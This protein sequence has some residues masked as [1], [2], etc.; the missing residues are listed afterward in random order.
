MLDAA[1]ETLKEDK[2]FRS[3]ALKRL[4]IKPSAVKYSLSEL[5]KQIQEAQSPRR[6]ASIFLGAA[7]DAQKT[8]E[9]KGQSGSRRVGHHVQDFV[10]K[11]AGFV[12]VYAGFV[13]LIRQ[14]NG[15]YAEAAYSTLSLFFMVSNKTAKHYLVDG[16]NLGRHK[17]IGE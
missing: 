6:E 17:Q 14:A 11:F 16:N 12:R 9:E 10:T 15:G 8:W 4:R 3:K 1:E 7:G 13:D 5:E 2:D